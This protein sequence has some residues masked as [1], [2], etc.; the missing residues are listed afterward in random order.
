[1]KRGRAQG[2][3]AFR[4]SLGKLTFLDPACGCGNFLIIA[5][6]ELRELELEVLAASFETNVKMTGEN[7]IEQFQRREGAKGLSVIDVDQFYGIEFEEFPALIGEIAMYMMD[8]IMNNKLSLE[9]NIPF[10]RIPLK[11][12]PSIKQSN[13][14]R[15][16]WNELL[17]ANK[18]SYILGNPP[19]IGH[20]QR[21]SLQK[22]DMHLV[23]GVDG[24]FNR[25]DYVA[26]W[27]KKA[28]DYAF[29][30]KAIRIAYVSTNS[31]TQ[32]EQ[33]GILWPMIFGKGLS[34]FFAHR[35]FQWNSEA[36]GTAAVHCII[37]GLTF[38]A[39]Q[40]PSIY[41]YERVRGEPSK[42]IVRSVNGY[43]I[44]GPQYALPA[45]GQPQAGFLKMFKGSQPTDGARTK[46]PDGG[47]ITTSN[48]ILDNLER[49]QFL[50][51]A[52]DAI[53][54]LRP[55]VGGDELIS[56]EYR[57]CLWLK[58][59]DPSEIRN[60][61]PIL[62]RLERVRKGRLKSPT[63]SVR[64]FAHYPTLF[65]QDRQ[66]NTAYMAIPEVSSESREYVPIAMLG[67]DIIASNKLQIIVGANLVY[68][69]ILNSACHMAWMRTV[70]GRLKSDYSYSP[71]VYNTFPWPEMSPEQEAK[72]STLAQ[73]VLDARAAWPDS[74]LAHLYDPD[75][76]PPNLRKA[77][78]TLDLAVD[79]LYRKAPFASE[80]E[81]V[82]HLFGLYEKMVAPL[83]AAA[84]AKP[85]RAKKA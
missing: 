19:F 58:D 30:N 15:F 13:A 73:A 32:G 6:R 8:H 7:P 24:Q 57:W 21:D 16:D 45:R 74:T 70:T 18:C 81:R 80:R 67:P 54:W 47:Y 84:K 49:V 41:E 64:A 29:L 50:R 43:L 25:L 38:D 72:I 34:I 53:R 62:D 1:M 11:K 33:C 39:V 60:F 63:E 31:I 82:E 2:L 51:D 22:N 9:F 65:T 48:L 69:G 26:C 12:S 17:L 5:Y 10:N 23:W 44:D 40:S 83:E 36:R 42:S 78:H 35:T 55:F 28:M 68:F 71:T 59:A 66:P 14:L 46:N 3:E 27:F 52:P 77:H 76:M 85:K 79:R 75:L 56:G 37:V 61:Q 20:Q 4:Q